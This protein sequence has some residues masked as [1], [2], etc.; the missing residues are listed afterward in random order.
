MAE[1]GIANPVWI[2]TDVHF[3]EAFRDSPTLNPEV[4]FFHGPASPA[5][6][7]TFAGSRHWFNFGTLEVGARGDLAAQVVN[8]AG[9]PQFSL[10]LDPH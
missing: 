9:A 5:D 10:R 1:N 3:A 7:T 4:L 8:T 6:V 2:T